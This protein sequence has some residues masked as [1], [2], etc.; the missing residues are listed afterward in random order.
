VGVG[1]APTPIFCV[2]QAVCARRVRCGVSGPLCATLISRQRLWDAASAP[3]RCPRYATPAPHS[4]SASSSTWPQFFPSQLPVCSSYATAVLRSLA[5]TS[6]A[7]TGVP[8]GNHTGATRLHL[9]FSTGSPWM[10]LRCHIKVT[11][12]LQAFA[13]AL[14]RLDTPTGE[15]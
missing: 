2:R 15:W 3:K 14:S 9:E 11:V 12:G 5:T 13:P 8:R 10:L 4:C 6:H 1:H 7:F